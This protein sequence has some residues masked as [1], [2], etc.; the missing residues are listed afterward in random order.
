[1]LGIILCVFVF[2]GM[3]VHAVCVYTCACL[4]MH[5]WQHLCVCVC[6]CVCVCIFHLL[7]D[8][9]ISLCAGPGDLS[10]VMM[11]TGLVMVTDC[12][13]WWFQLR[14]TSH[15][16]A[17]LCKTVTAITQIMIWSKLPVFWAFCEVFGCVW[18]EMCLVE[19]KSGCLPA[20]S[21]FSSQ[22]SGT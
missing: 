5:I 21:Y 22:F 6:V 4:H 18:S 14:L 15:Y 3:S 11:V 7:I 12:E 9:S 19:Q 10:C 8:K 1:M 16:H 20:S 13:S 2:V 17:S